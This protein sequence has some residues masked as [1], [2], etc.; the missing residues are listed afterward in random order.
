MSIQNEHA[1]MIDTLERAINDSKLALDSLQKARVLVASQ[2]DR[3]NNPK[4]REA[5]ETIASHLE[6]VAKSLG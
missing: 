5:L 2:L 4:G 3:V 1:R 6:D